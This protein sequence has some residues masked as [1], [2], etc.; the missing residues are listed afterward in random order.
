MN[1]WLAN[2]NERFIE[3]HYKYMI[4]Q[5]KYATHDHNV[6][7][8][9]KKHDLI[10]LYLNEVG[11]IAVGFVEEDFDEVSKFGLAKRISDKVVEKDS[12]VVALEQFVLVKWIWSID[13]PK[14]LSKY[15]QEELKK[16]KDLLKNVAIDCNSIR[17]NLN[18]IFLPTLFNATKVVNCRKLFVEISKKLV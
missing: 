17:D 16:L 11:V 15:S 1:I 5:N 10:L 13:I 7:Q 3:G 6:I 2:T 18:F 4:K 14:N 9:L 12:S 8:K